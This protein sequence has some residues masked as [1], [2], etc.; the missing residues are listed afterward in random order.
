VVQKQYFGRFGA[1]A[2]V[3]LDDTSSPA[4]AECPPVLVLMLPQPSCRHAGWVLLVVVLLVLPSL[5]MAARWTEKTIQED[6]MRRLEDLLRSDEAFHHAGIEWAVKRVAKYWRVHRTTIRRWHK[7]YRKYGEVPCLTRRWMRK[8]L[9]R[10]GR[11]ARSRAMSQAHLDALQGIVDRHPEYYLD[12]FV[13]ALHDET[14]VLFSPTTVW[15]ALREK[16]GC[17][18]KVMSERAK[19]QN[20]G[21]R[22][23]FMRMLHYYVKDVRQVLIID[24]SSKGR[25]ASRRRRGWGTRGVELIVSRWFEDSVNYCLIAACNVDGFIP[26]ACWPVPTTESTSL[27]GASGTITSD[28]FFRYFENFVVPV[29]GSYAKREANSIVI[30]DNASIH[31]AIIEKMESLAWEEKGAIILFT[32]PYS[33]DLNPIEYFF[34]V[35]KAYLKREHRRPREEWELVHREAL[36]AVTAGAARRTFAK[37]DFPFAADLVQEEDAEEDAAA[38]AAVAAAAAAILHSYS[39]DSSSVDLDL[40]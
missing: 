16:L 36:A 2:A 7:H 3:A 26:R 30:M 5:A 33:P 23:G 17:S 35:Y 1:V 6:A 29:L 13:D 12:E 40:N 18:L 21:E 27:T 11:R 10:G 25:N 24:E 19:N 4:P 14:G 34:S 31:H 22:R 20:E 38:A 39:Q 8:Y 15:R 9:R 32:A 28:I 37:C